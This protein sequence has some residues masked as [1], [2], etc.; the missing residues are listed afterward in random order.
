MKVLI[1]LLILSLLGN[2][3]GLFVLYKF[4]QKDKYLQ[5]VM[6]DLQ[7]KDEVI[8]KVNR[9]LDTRMVFVH[10]SVGRNWLN[11]GGLRD[12]LV[13]RGI[14][15]RSVTYGCPIGENTDMRDWLP[16]FRDHLE[17]IIRFDQA[18]DIPFGGTEENDI[19]MFKSCY[20]N[21]EIAAD[22]SE[23]GDPNVPTATVT[24]YE[25][26]LGSIE[27]F[28]AEH[29]HKLFI[30]V[31][32]P[33]LASEATTPESAA[34]ARKFNQWV[35]SEFVKQYTAQTGKDNLRVF[36]LY[37][38]LSDPTTNCLRESFKTASGDSHPNRAGSRAATKAFMKFLDENDIRAGHLPT[39]M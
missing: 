10:H 23:P 39:M 11:E 12:S 22:G 36:D 26:V 34:R 18:P 7:R 32:A 14:A 29:P 8:A 21:S 9:D 28:M 3:F 4:M 6:S 5:E 37:D 1:V 33:P 15:V 19:I 2:A 24:N 25:A 35:A 38:V 30:Y 13:S 17:Q 31:T 20:P 16:K 27:P